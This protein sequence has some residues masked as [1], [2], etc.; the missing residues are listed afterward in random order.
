VNDACTKVGNMVA[1]RQI[2]SADGLQ[3]FSVVQSAGG[4]RYIEEAHIH[5][6]K[7]YGVD[8]YWYW[9]ITHESGIYGTEQEAF[10]N[11]MGIISWLKN[12]N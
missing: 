8:D 7:R 3:V 5:E 2:V 9:E 11:G 6:P 1:L 4:F 10:D 12:S